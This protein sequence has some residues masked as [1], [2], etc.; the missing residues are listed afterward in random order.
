MRIRTGHGPDDWE[1]G[2]PASPGS[3]KIGGQL[4]V[5]GSGANDRDKRNEQV[6]RYKAKVKAAKG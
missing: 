1:Y 4:V 3:S 5:G 2:P 6:A